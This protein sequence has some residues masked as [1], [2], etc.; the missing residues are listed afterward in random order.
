MFK[1]V[2]PLGIIWCREKLR[3]DVIQNGHCCVVFTYYIWILLFLSSYAIGFW[4]YIY[5]LVSWLVN[6]CWKVVVFY[7][8]SLLLFQ[9]Q[10]WP[11]LQSCS[12]RFTRNKR[13]FFLQMVPVGFLFYFLWFLVLFTLCAAL[14]KKASAS[15]PCPTNR[16][17][18]VL[19]AGGNVIPFGWL[20]S[21][22][23]FTF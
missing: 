8:Q 16:I 17:E 11:W 6:R 9:P 19:P 23:W 13:F 10:I 21:S 1:P 15:W 3:A 12:V 22:M 2:A 14:D 20:I 5:I 4:N 18:L 7:A